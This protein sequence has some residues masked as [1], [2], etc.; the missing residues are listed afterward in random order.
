MRPIPGH[1]LAG[2]L[3]LAVAVACGCAGA[4]T[5]EGADAMDAAMPIA[6]LIERHA[7]EWMARDDVVGVYESAL[8]DGTPCIKIMA[9]A[10]TPELR[11]AFPDPFHGHPL[12]LQETGPVAPRNGS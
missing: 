12:R 2:A 3:G 9:V 4:P 1:V 7:A 10:I 6:E 8:P 11:A 5:V